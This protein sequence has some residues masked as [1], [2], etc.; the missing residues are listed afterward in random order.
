MEQ[1]RLSADWQL[2]QRGLASKMLTTSPFFSASSSINSREFWLH[3]PELSPSQLQYEKNMT[4][5]IQPDEYQLPPADPWDI[6]IFKGG[7]GSGK[8]LGG[9]AWVQRKLK[10]EGKIRVGVMAPTASDVRG[11]C[12]EGESGLLTLYPDIWR[13]VNRSADGGWEAWTIYGGYVRGLTSEKPARWNGPQWHYLWVD[14]AE[15]C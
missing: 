7:R 13:K 4:A 12:L 11:T 10:A 15:L 8:T 14:E 1:Q 5:G 9:A 3:D 2:I 6:W